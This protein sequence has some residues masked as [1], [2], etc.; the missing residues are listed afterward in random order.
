ML[1]KAEEAGLVHMTG[2]VQVGH[3]YICNCC[4]C[5]CGVLRA[6]NDFG[7]PASDVINSHYYAEIDAELCSVAGL[8]R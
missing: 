3:I 8:C 6:I 7:I 1:K 5:C 2:N 4:K